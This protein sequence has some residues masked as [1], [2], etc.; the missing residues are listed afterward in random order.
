MLELRQ[1]PAEHPQQVRLFGRRAVQFPG[2]LQTAVP[3]RI[4][5]LVQGLDKLPVSATSP[6]M[7]SDKNRQA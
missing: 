5:V 6:D 7:Y 2:E 4:I 3:E 1:Q